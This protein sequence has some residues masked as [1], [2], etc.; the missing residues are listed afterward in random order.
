MESPLITCPKCSATFPLSS[1]IERQLVDRIRNEATAAALESSS[2]HLRELTEKLA[3][4]DKKLNEAQQAELKLR[5][6][7]EAFEEQKRAFDLELARRADEVKDAVRKERDDEF[8]LKEA[9]SNKK[10]DDLK[11]QID[12]LKRK[13]EQGSEQTQGEVLELDLEGALRRCFID[14]EIVPVPT[15][16]SG[17]DLL[18][19]V[20]DEA[21]HP[22]G[23]IIWECKRTKTW[24]D[25][26]LL[27]LKDDKLAAK[28]Q[29]AVLVSMTMPKDVASF[30]C[31]EGVWVAPPALAV[32][33][34]A[35]LR[36]SLIETASAK[37]A[38]DGR[39]DKMEVVYDYL[40][41][42]EFKGRVEAIVEAFSAMA[43][44]LEAEKIAIQKL[45]AKRAKQLERVLT[46]TAGLYGDLSGIFGNTLPAIDRLEL[47][48]STE[49]QT[50]NDSDDLIA[51]RLQS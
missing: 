29:L 8:R 40:S 17:G 51:R 19:L 28:A 2:A 1:A 24:N 15:G 31:R 25:G 27:K 30:E 3:A 44:D 34:A 21:R 23:A 7:R 20:H 9:E 18:Q 32:P 39:H 22:C 14:D 10:M 46:N 37:R 43:K 13:A 6:E 42:P 49:A 12:E 41:G 48:S 4:K 38:I 33:L 35:A 36:I 5:R 45:W 16:V 11:R 50:E 47:I 26:W